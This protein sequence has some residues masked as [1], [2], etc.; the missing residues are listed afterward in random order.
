MGKQ[1]YTTSDELFSSPEPSNSFEEL[2]QELQKE[3]MGLIVY[4]NT[5]AGREAA[6]WRESECDFLFQ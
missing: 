6:A 1:K 2:R 5:S 3:A 4:C